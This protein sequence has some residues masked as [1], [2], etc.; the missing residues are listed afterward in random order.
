[1]KYAWIK[2]HELSYPRKVMCGVLSVSESGFAEWRAGSTAKRWLST[3]Q[4]ITTIRAIHARLTAPTVR[5]A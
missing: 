1:M 4:L 2:R 5:R 3:P